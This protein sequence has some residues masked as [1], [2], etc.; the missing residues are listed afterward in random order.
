[1]QACATGCVVAGGAMTLAY[2]MLSR[3]TSDAAAFR[4]SQKTYEIAKL[5]GG[6]TAYRDLGKKSARTV[7]F[8]HGATLGSLAYAPIVDGFVARGYRVLTYDGYGRGF[9][10]R[11]DPAPLSMAL[12]CQQLLELMDHC[13]IPVAALYG[14]SLG[15][16]IAAR[17]AVVHPQRVAAVAF[18]APLIKAPRNPKLAL[19]RLPL[20]RLWL[21]RIVMIPTIL[22]RGESID[23][24]GGEQAHRVLAHFREQFNVRGT[25]RDLLSLL[26]G[27]AVSDRVED[28]AAIAATSLPVYFVYA[29]DDPEMP[30]ALVEATIA[31]HPEKA[32]GAKAFPEGGHF[33]S[34]G[35]HAELAEGF[36]GFLRKHGLAA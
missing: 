11:A 2:M 17:F 27:C 28:H 34:K 3:E 1:M 36:H 31:M 5:S 22:A 6:V 4:Q 13:D 35:R 21:A 33:F 15:A 30:R 18:E 29:L 12:L 7:V 24:E 14:T 25:E 19:L 8:I 9:S 16:A 10:D 32:R 23:E 26:T 20:L